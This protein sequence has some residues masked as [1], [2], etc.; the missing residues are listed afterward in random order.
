MTPDQRW[1]AAMWPFVRGHLPLAPARP[2]SGVPSTPGVQATRIQHVRDLRCAC[3]GRSAEP[4]ADG[5]HP[6]GVAGVDGVLQLQQQHAGLL[7]GGGTVGHP[8][9]HHEEFARSQDDGVVV[10][11]LDA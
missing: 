1:L 7:V 11:E 5:A 2:R 9:W 10:L 4:L 6:V 3:C 8:T